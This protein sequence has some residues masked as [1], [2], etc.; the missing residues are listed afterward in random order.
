MA[1]S[2]KGLAGSGGLVSVIVMGAIM[3]LILAYQML[4]FGTQYCAYRDIFG[5]DA[6]SEQTPQ[7]NEGQFVA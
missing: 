5:I 4:I 1:R 7:D 3:I 2:G 6:P